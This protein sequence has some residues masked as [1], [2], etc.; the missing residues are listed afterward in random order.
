MSDLFNIIY[1]K[2]VPIPAFIM[3]VWGVLYIIVAYSFFI[4]PDI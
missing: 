3:S 2:N 1:F 4:L